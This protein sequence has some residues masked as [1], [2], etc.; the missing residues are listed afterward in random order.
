MGTGN[1]TELRESWVPGSHVLR[2]V[3]KLTPQDRVHRARE[4]YDAAHS[5]RIL[6]RKREEAQSLALQVRAAFAAAGRCGR[7]A[8]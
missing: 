8:R 3:S 1:W 4:R 5:R 6:T 2:K 7:K